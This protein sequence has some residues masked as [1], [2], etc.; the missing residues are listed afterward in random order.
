MIIK[1]IFILFLISLFFLG[2]VVLANAA[3]NVMIAPNAIGM[4]ASRILLIRRGSEYCA[5]K[6]HPTGRTEYEMSMEYE[7]YY[8]GD[9]TGDFNNK[10]VKYLKEEVYVSKPKFTFLTYIIGHAIR[11][12][13][14]NIHCGSIELA[15]SEGLSYFSTYFYRHDQEQSFYDIQL[16]PTP[17]TDISQV[18]VF[19]S[20]VKWYRYDHRRKDVFIPVEKLWELKLLEMKDTSIGSGL[21]K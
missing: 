19:D 21:K 5:V 20:R 8:Q 3:D 15:W 10:N 7:S 12:G 13:S 18:N 14:P 9:R 2:D 17:W 1:K 6:F 4:P 11:S 16:A